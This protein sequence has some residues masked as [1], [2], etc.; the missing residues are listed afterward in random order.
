VIDNCI[1]IAENEN[2]I[3]TTFGDVFASPFFSCLSIIHTDCKISKGSN[4][5]G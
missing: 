5:A 1:R 2:V 4:P 3:F